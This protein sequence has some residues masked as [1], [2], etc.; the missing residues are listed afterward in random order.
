MFPGPKYNSLIEKDPQIVKI[1][2]DIV[3][4]GARRSGMPR[5]SDPQVPGST[6]NAPSAPEMGIKHV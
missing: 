1:S 6:A 2:P 4:I 5:G 3:E